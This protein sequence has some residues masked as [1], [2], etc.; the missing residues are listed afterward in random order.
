[1]AVCVLIFSPSFSFLL[2]WLVVQCKLPGRSFL[3]FQK[4]RTVVPSRAQEAPLGHAIVEKQSLSK[5]KLQS[6]QY[7][8][9]SHF[10][11]TPV[12]RKIPLH[13]S[14]CSLRLAAAAI[15]LR[16]RL[17]QYFSLYGLQLQ[18]SK[19]L[20]QCRLVASR[21]RPVTFTGRAQKPCRRQVLPKKCVLLRILYG[22]SNGAFRWIHSIVSVA[23]VK[24]PLV[25]G[26]R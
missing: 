22:S 11:S 24:Q 1:L 23:N 19:Q 21:T 20:Q 4:K 18:Q 3:S 13:W 25:S 16:L 6:R 17:L 8:T 7:Y 10:H 14:A 2:T 12:E 5:Q 15:R 26:W 9:R